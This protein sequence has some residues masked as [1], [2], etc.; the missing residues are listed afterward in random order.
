MESPPLDVAAW[1]ERGVAPPPSSRYRL[2][3]LNQV[4]LPD[5]AN[6]RHGLQP[7][8]HLTANGTIRAEA[9]VDEPVDIAGEI[10]M[11]PGAGKILQFEWYLGTKDFAYEPATKLTEPQPRVSATRT[12]SFPAP[13]EYTITLRTH[14]QRDGAG[15]TTSATLLQNLARVRVV[16]R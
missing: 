4:V 13:G 8:V 6:E 5:T 14:A 11:P 16:V 2:D 1:A 3:A 15:D 9:A 12:V 10:E 7:V